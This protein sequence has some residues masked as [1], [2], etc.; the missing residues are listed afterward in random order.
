MPVPWKETLA[1]AEFELWSMLSTAVEVK[2]F[3]R[4]LDGYTASSNIRKLVHIPFVNLKKIE[5]AC[6]KKHAFPN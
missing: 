6:R 2:R 3:C 1:I 4:N 5:A